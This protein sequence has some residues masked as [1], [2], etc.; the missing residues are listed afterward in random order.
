MSN[1]TD[2]ILYSI[3]QSVPPGGRQVV[4]VFTERQPAEGYLNSL[5]DGYPKLETSVMNNKE[6]EHRA[7]CKLELV[8]IIALGLARSA[9]LSE[10]PAPP[11][12]RVSGLTNQT[13]AVPV[14][15]LRCVLRAIERDNHELRELMVA[16]ELVSGNPLNVLAAA[17]LAWE[18]DQIRAGGQMCN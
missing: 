14:A 18:R 11:Q 7:L 3:T 13:V 16:R 10:R 9:K 5:K 15:A 2:T 8:D 1:K 4:A 12:P 17:L 6:A